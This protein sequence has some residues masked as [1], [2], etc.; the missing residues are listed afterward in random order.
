MASTASTSLSETKAQGHVMRPIQ[1]SATL[2]LLTVD[3]TT[4]IQSQAGQQNAIL[5]P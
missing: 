5:S 2:E 3:I 1:W 4:V